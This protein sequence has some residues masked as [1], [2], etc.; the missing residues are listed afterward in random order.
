MYLNAKLAFLLCTCHKFNDAFMTA[1][2]KMYENSKTVATRHY[3]TFYITLREPTN[4][5]KFA[6]KDSHF[7]FADSD[8]IIL[9]EALQLHNNDMLSWEM[10]KI[11][12]N[13]QKQGI[14]LDIYKIVSVYTIAALIKYY[15]DAGFKYIFIPVVI[16]YG[17]SDTLLHQAALIID[18]TGKF[19]FYEPYGKYT[20]FGKSYAEAVCE[21]FHIFDDCELFN[22]SNPIQCMTY[23]QFLGLD[24]HLNGGIQHILLERNN[25]RS[26]I[27]DKEY[28]QTL[29]ELKDAFPNYEI[30]PQYTTS[31]QDT[32]DHTFKIL[33]LLFNIDEMAIDKKAANTP[34]DV[35]KKKTY[36][37][38]L[39]KVLEHYCC[40]NSKTCVTITLVEMNEFFKYVEY[41]NDKNDISTK[42]KNLYDEFKIPIPNPILMKKL[43]SMLTVFQNSDEIREIVSNSSHISDT[44]S[45]LFKSN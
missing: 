10:V 4:K 41:N 9:S 39:H 1:M 36:E 3:F 43:N 27:F 2:T 5:D 15:K 14:S 24:T 21:F 38:L 22:T 11:Y 29:S 19:L 34:S 25:A 18:F 35:E 33:D 20:K 12:E 40:Y 13:L 42:I 7:K 23:H 31:E 8:D 32:Q 6:V 30:E 26:A 16:N 17:R 44:C 45:K 37:R 28:N